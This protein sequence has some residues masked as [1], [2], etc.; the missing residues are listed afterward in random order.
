MYYRYCILSQTGNETTGMERGSYQAIRDKLRKENFHIL[1]LE[2]DL[3]KSLDFYLKR[4]KIKTHA[5]AEFF[6]DLS[7]TLETGLS[8]HEA[9]MT[10]E[11]STVEPALKRALPQIGAGLLRGLSLTEAFSQT[12]VFPWQVLS[13][14]RVGEKSGS[15]ERVFGDLAGHYSRE[16]D[17]LRSLRGALVYP[18]VIFCLLVA[19]MFYVSFQVIPHLEALLPIK[20]NAHF[21][22]RLL[23]SL[24][25][26]LKDYWFVCLSVPF[27]LVFVFSRLRTSQIDRIRDFYHRIP[28]VGPLIK[29][30]ACSFL[31]SDLAI[32]Q[33]N[34]IGIIEA[35][36]LVEET[37]IDK[38]FA[39]KI[40]RVK[41]AVM[42][43]LSLWQ[44][45]KEAA[46]FPKPVYSSIR[47]GEEMGSLDKYLQNLAGSYFKKVTRRIDALLSFIQPAFLMLCASLLL[48]IV[49][50]FIIP[51][52]SNLSNIAGGNVKF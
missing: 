28:V 15:L 23:L 40:R 11:E 32:L 9:I 38:F 45:L 29:D 25:H 50:A 37:A 19:V 41:D 39:D 24:N 27:A 17:F 10:L 20:E 48:F 51:V 13:M 6:E 8:I 46:F 35:L 18:S 47:K 14:L 26:F 2:P 52:Y 34:G 4:K 22:T 43:G 1:S 5:L 12:E 33:R 21:A 44:A 49:S 31:F 36:T 30:M 3:I 42:S 7:N 16:A